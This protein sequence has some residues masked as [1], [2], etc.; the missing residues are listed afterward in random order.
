LLTV[1]MKALRKQCWLKHMPAFQPILDTKDKTKIDAARRKI[2]SV[3][4]GLS[5]AID[6]SAMLTKETFM[7]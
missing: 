3:C 1:T 7:T 4:A 6:D 5:K 2:T